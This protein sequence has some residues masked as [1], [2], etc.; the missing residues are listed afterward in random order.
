MLTGHTDVVTS[1]T[2]SRDGQTLASGSADKT[3]RLWDA[4]TGEP[5]QT[6][7]G[8]TD[9]VYSVVFSRDGQ[10]LASGSKDKTVRLWG[11]RNRWTDTDAHTV[12]RTPSI[13]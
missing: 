4:E 3:V 6:F 2:F 9:A 13:A 10:V 11:C 5:K 8:H 7:T 12:I 1:V